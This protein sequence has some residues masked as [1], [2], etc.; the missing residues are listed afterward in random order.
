MLEELGKKIDLTGQRFGKWTVL[1]EAERRGNAR[2]WKCK[3]ECGNEKEVYQSSL[4]SNRTESCGCNRK[5]RR[6]IDLTG[7]RF[8]KWTVLRE[9]EKRTS[10]LRWECRCDCGNIKNVNGQTLRNGSS[11][12]C[13]CIRE[14][15]KQLE[16]RRYERLLV[17]HMVGKNDKGQILWSCICDCGNETQA[18][19][20][21]LN[22]GLMSCG[23]ARVK[24]LVGSKFGKLTVV[25]DSGERAGGNVIWNC[26]CECGNE[27]NVN[28]SNLSSNGVKSCGCTK[29]LNLTG[30]R[31]GKLKVLEKSEFRQNGRILWKCECECG[32]TIS[33]RG[34][35][36]TPGKTDCGCGY[37]EFLKSRTGKEH[38][39]YNPKISDEQRMSNRYQLHG[40]SMANW[41]KEIFNSDDYVCQGC[42]KRGHTL[43]A[44]HLNAWNAFPEQRFD[45][46]NGITLCSDCHKEFH[47]FNGYGDNTLEEFRDHLACLVGEEHVSEIEETL[48]SRESEIIGQ[49][50]QTRELQTT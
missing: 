29:G 5:T 34:D 7:Q 43:N 44:H 16:G 10:V 26:I 17:S 31:F 36:L 24:D 28:S 18:T 13:G 25:R 9:S 49:E 30:S 2:Y 12:N 39:S 32:R 46:A 35:A 33:L 14:Q 1:E 8:G 47:H 21:S 20:G 37:I 48:L 50:Q 45:T 15:A 11:T 19:T 27:T 22:G 23:C 40:F 3:C 41:R 38:H 4:T 6:I 42:G